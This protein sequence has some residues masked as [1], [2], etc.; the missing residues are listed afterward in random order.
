MFPPVLILIYKVLLIFKITSIFLFLIITTFYFWSDLHYGD[1]KTR[2][3][4]G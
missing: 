1:G 2:I 3:I 4:K